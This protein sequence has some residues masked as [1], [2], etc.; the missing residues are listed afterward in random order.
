M[1]FNGRPPFEPPRQVVQAGACV[2]YGIIALCVLGVVFA[3]V[4][5]LL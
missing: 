2:Y 3:G 1:G 4:L 5:M